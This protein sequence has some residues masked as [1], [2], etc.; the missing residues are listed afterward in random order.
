MEGLIVP[1]RSSPI[2]GAVR[3]PRPAAPPGGIVGQLAFDGDSWFVKEAGALVANCIYF[4]CR[5]LT[6][7]AVFG[8]SS[9]LSGWHGMCNCEILKERARN[10]VR[11]IQAGENSAPLGVLVEKL[12]SRLVSFEGN[13]ARVLR[14]QA[15]LTDPEQIGGTATARIRAMQKPYGMT[16]NGWAAA[17]VGV[18]IALSLPDSATGQVVRQAAGDVVTGAGRGAR[19]AG[20]TAVRTAE[21]TG[22]AAR[23]AGKVTWRG[24]RAVVRGTGRAVVTVAEVPVRFAGGA[25]RAIGG[26]DVRDHGAQMDYICVPVR[27][28]PRNVRFPRSGPLSGPWKG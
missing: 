9:G 28:E 3:V 13:R 16:K 4:C 26:A 19:F 2:A 12:A 27:R 22:R 8:W 7:A 6:V 24:S 20:R 10:A 18:A 14:E 21:F 25:A 17:C 11:T 5:I 23:R 15:S 1:N